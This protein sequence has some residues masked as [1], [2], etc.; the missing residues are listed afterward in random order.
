MNQAA[1][2]LE[3]KPLC[4]LFEKNLNE[5]TRE[6]LERPPRPEKLKEKLSLCQYLQEALTQRSVQDDIVEKLILEVK[7]EGHIQFIRSG[8]K[9][10]LPTEIR[11]RFC[12]L[13]QTFLK[14][15]ECGEVSRFLAIADYRRRK[16]L[17]NF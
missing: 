13:C 8:F 9:I 17:L 11:A 2:E 5:L 4:C 16:N 7:L 15:V 10:T 1:L 14:D 6:L 3:N 12:S